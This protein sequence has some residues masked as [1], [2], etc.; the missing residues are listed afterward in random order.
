MG[1]CNIYNLD[2]QGI[3]AVHNKA[4]SYNFKI[5]NRFYGLQFFKQIF[6]RLKYK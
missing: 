3:I 1:N 6:N 2:N 4:L 5:I